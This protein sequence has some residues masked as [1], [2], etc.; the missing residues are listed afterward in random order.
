MAASPKIPLNFKDINIKNLKDKF[1]F[2]LNKKVFE[3]I[4]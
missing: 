2:R 4:V 1:V 3:R